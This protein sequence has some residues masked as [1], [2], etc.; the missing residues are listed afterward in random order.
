MQIDLNLL[1]CWV[2]Y[3]VFR[4]S[5]SGHTVFNVFK[6]HHKA[7]KH[8]TNKTNNL[9][10]SVKLFLCKLKELGHLPNL[11]RLIFYPKT[12]VAD[13]KTYQGIY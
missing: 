4:K 13:V 12:T 10:D 2:F 1:I 11:L 5:I 6:S 9:Y 7:D 3:L 8:L